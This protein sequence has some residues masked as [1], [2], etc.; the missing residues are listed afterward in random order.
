MTFELAIIIIAA[1][2]AVILGL[3]C[4]HLLGRLEMLERSVQGGLQPP[5]TRLSREQFERRFRTAHARSELAR[6][7]GTGVVLITGAEY[8]AESELAATMEHLLRPD[9]ITRRDVTEIDASTLGVATTPYLF[10]V[11]AD[12][13]RHAQPLAGSQDLISALER[14]A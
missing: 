8:T 1:I 10:I 7:I 4:Y 2:A 5:S 14:F 9:L 6:E 13:I 3:V 12:R 11:D